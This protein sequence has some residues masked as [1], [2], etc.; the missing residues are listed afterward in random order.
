M[1]RIGNMNCKKIVAYNYIDTYLCSP[2]LANSFIIWFIWNTVDSFGSMSPEGI[3]GSVV[4]NYHVSVKA[5]KDYV[6][7]NLQKGVGGYRLSENQK[8]I[9]NSVQDF[10]TL[11]QSEE[12]KKN[13]WIGKTINDA[14]AIGK[15]DSVQTCVAVGKLD[16][17]S[18]SRSDID[19]QILFFEHL[20]EQ[21]SDTDVINQ[22]IV[23]VLSEN[24]S[25]PLNVYFSDQ[26]LLKVFAMGGIKDIDQLLSEDARTLTDV[27]F[28]DEDNL[29]QTLT[30]MSETLKV[31][32]EIMC[33]LFYAS[34][35][36]RDG[37]PK[38]A[39][40]D[41]RHGIG[42]GLTSQTL[43]EVGQKLGLTRERVRQLEVIGDKA[44]VEH[45][46]PIINY[47]ASWLFQTF[48]D[49]KIIQYGEAKKKYGEGNGVDVLAVASSISQDQRLAYDEGLSLFY[50]PKNTSL[51][52][53]KFK[54]LDGLNEILTVS[55]FSKHKA[56]EQKII[57]SEYS[58]R[59]CGFY[60]RKNKPTSY[61]I[62]S[63]ID[64]F[65]PSGYHFNGRDYSDLVGCLKKTDRKS[66]V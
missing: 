15:I 53:I 39:A 10:R 43:E 52:E 16:Q 24:L 46:S 22:A 59:E 1:A 62:T 2:E 8:R 54:T 11:F 49:F 35:E 42:E 48:G 23:H 27:F 63:V 47:G 65:F 31:S 33:N 26:T 45:S 64:R 4:E 41:L 30:G 5:V 36:K 7:E 20:V 28:L 12:I 40:F 29:C 57:S 19:Y 25:V 50:S 13:D 3:A 17:I 18:N 61:L 9:L 51:Y 6:R 14:L 32:L 21:S 66:V 56:F 38:R 55:E 44:L 60:L 58:L 34:L 37:S